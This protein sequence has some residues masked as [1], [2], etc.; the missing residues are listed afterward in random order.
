MFSKYTVGLYTQGESSVEASSIGNYENIAL[1][2]HGAGDIADTWLGKKDRY[3]FFQDIFNEGY[4]VLSP[5][6]GGSQTWGNELQQNGITA[7]YNYIKL[8]TGRE[9]ITLIGQSMGGL[10]AIIWAK[11]NPEKVDRLAA[12]IPVINLEDLHG[13]TDYYP[14][15]IDAAYGGHYDDSL[16]GNERNP[17]RIAANGDLNGVNM[18]IWYGLGDELC[19]PMYA[20][21]FANSSGCKLIPVIGGHEEITVS[22]VA[23]ERFRE[24][25]RWR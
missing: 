23:G 16:I 5:L 7:A 9:K 2:V 8:K 22:R 12:V 3:Q 17:L 19:K 24:F 21:E 25:I 20:V 10:G 1:Y 4:A 11:N 13:R 18:C 14:G 6:L 15:L